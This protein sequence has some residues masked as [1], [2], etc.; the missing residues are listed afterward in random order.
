MPSR[1]DTPWRGRLPAPAQDSNA[2][3]ENSSQLSEPDDW[4]AGAEVVARAQ[5]ISLGDIEVSLDGIE[6]PPD[7]NVA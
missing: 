5:E 2:M 7:P 1:T 6:P 4:L 3:D